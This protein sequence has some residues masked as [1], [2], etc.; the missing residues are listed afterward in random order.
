MKHRLLI[1]LASLLATNVTLAQTPAAASNCESSAVSKTGKPL[2]GAAKA[3]YMKKCASEAAPVA[4]NG[5]T[6]QQNKMVQCNKEAKGKKGDERK[7]FMK[8][9]LSR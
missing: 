1:I 4:T 6:A 5:K 9:C 3:A 7:T 2:H 8:E